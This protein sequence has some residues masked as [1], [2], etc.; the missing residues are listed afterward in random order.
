MQRYV[1]V[2]IE[3]K[4]K[5]IVAILASIIVLVCFLYLASLNE[6]VSEGIK[7]NQTSTAQGSSQT[8]GGE[9]EREAGT[10][11]RNVGNPRTD[12]HLEDSRPRPFT[13]RYGVMT[14][15]EFTVKSALKQQS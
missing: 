1:K 4:R 6:F 5:L 2:Q 10:G 12:D 9:A 8:R 11:E 13:R 15:D 14:A 3:K 7:M